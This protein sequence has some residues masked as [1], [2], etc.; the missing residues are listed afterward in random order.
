MATYTETKATLDEIA[1]RSESNRKRLE[2][3][4]G[5]VAAALSDLSG[6]AAAYGAFITQLNADAAANPTDDAWKLA[7]SEKNQLVSDFQALDARAEAMNTAI[8][9]L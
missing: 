7:K 1:Q 4:K 6:M 8:T 5:Q 2:Q 9:G 3:A